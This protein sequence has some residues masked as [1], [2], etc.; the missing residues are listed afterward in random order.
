MLEVQPRT[1]RPECTL[2]HCCG[3]TG[4]LGLRRIGVTPSIPVRYRIGGF[5]LTTT[6]LLAAVRTAQSIP[7]A[8]RLARVLGVT[9]Q[10]VYNWSHGHRCP[11]DVM[12]VRLADLAGLD[13]AHVLACIHAQRCTDAAVAS[14]WRTIAQRAQ[15]AAALVL[16]VFLSGFITYTPDA[17]ARATIEK[18]APALVSVAR[19]TGYTLSRLSGNRT[20]SQ[21]PFLAG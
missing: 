8:Y 20:L 7:S 18:S 9:D 14:V 19:F 17:Q 15:A 10:T 11:D 13:R 2:T 21:C 6:E 5:M 16:A 3:S 4:R 12:S 1:R